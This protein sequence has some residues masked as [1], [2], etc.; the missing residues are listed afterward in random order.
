MLLTACV[1]V[2]IYVPMHLCTYAPMYTRGRVAWV[3][4]DS[5]RWIPLHNVDWLRFTL[6]SYQLPYS[7]EIFLKSSLHIDNA[8]LASLPE[9]L[10]CVP[11]CRLYRED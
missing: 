3:R 10:C 9:K 7:S 8:W 11:S 2:Y 4:L 6:A 1:Y 5:V